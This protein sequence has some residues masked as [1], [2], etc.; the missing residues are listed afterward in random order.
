M[1]KSQS[2]AEAPRGEPTETEMKQKGLPLFLLVVIGLLASMAVLVLL[3][4]YFAQQEYLRKCAT[5]CESWVLI[6]PLSA[7]GMFSVIRNAVTAAAA[8]GLGVTI[9]LSYRRQRVAEQTLTYTAE[10]QRL[11]VKAQTLETKRLNRE[12]LD[13]LRG[14]Y[15]DIATLLNANGDLN[16]IT[17]LH[18]LESLTISWRQFGDNR[19]ASASLGLLLSTQRLS[20]NSNS[21][22]HMEFRKTVRRTLERHMQ[23]DPEYYE[24]W[25]CLTV[26]A[27]GCLGPRGIEDWIV[28]GGDVTASP[29]AYKPVIVDG[30][31]LISGE[32]RVSNNDKDAHTVSP[33]NRVSGVIMENGV[34]RVALRTQ[35]ADVSVL[36]RKS[37]FMNGK[38][39][40]SNMVSHKGD[41]SYSF[42]ECHFLNVE[43]WFV[44]T[45]M[46]KVSFVKCTFKTNPLP[47]K[48]MQSPN[49]KVSFVDCFG[50]TES[51]GGMQ[52]V[53]L[54]DLATLPTV[55][56]PSDSVPEQPTLP[57]YRIFRRNR[58]Q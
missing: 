51:N 17:A 48:L 27:T 56:K 40:I 35:T 6:P 8:L 20:T 15:L 1:T 49:L 42:E 55:K 34:L 12:S 4:W 41:R 52:I 18:A 9:V 33:G 2:A 25:G 19:E 39:G 54:A 37:L 3:G 7:D 11:A 26:D 46:T 16:R 21:E 57:N 47:P 14:R 24:G 32:V 58:K 29:T 43:T 5:T 22:A 36:F 38:L 44:P 23:T 10:T 13:T 28:D 31:R 53:K 30:L 45:N 50:V